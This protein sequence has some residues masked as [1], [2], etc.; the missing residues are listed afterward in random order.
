MNIKIICIVDDMSPFLTKGKI[1]DAVID[2]HFFN[3]KGDWSIEYKIKNDLGQN[4]PYWSEC[5][6]T[7][8]EYRDNKINSII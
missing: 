7:L 2:E 3:I 4:L 1:Y 8:E 6:L 5:F